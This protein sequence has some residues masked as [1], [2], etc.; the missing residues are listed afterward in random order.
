MTDEMI[1]S[2]HPSHNCKT[3]M[4]IS[5]NCNNYYSVY[6]VLQELLDATLDVLVW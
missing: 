2:Y 1:S 5:V 6:F 4:K 3:D